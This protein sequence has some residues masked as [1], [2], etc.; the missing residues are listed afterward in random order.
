[1]PSALATVDL[2][3][4]EFHAP[5]L[6]SRPARRI[7]DDAEALAVVE[8]VSASLAKGAV[9]RDRDRILPYE[10][11]EL[12]SDAGLLAVTVPRVYG[13]AEVRAETVARIIAALSRADGSIGQIPQNHFF[14]LEALL[15]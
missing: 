5:A 13:G 9:A 1:M 12:I 3:T 4:R 7:R 15:L 14:M 6:R 2:E 8:E 11:M 10:E